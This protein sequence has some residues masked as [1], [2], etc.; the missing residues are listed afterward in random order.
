VSS[1]KNT[2]P[3]KAQVLL[4]VVSLQLISI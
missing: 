2:I 3:L 4:E 1:R